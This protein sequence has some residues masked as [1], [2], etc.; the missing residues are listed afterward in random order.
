MKSV[1]LFTLGLTLLLSDSLKAETVQQLAAS[2]S[3]YETYLVYESNVKQVAVLIDYEKV[4][5]DCHGLDYLYEVK[6]LAKN[7][8]I[9][10]KTLL[11]KP[12]NMCKTEFFQIQQQGI[13]IEI[14]VT[15][16]LAGSLAHAEIIVPTETE[17]SLQL[18]R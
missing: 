11:L 13:K 12:L 10:S 3:K 7:R 5:T 6:A 16:S 2:G 18:E 17:V 1:F 8:Y 4:E 15:S 9:V 14:P